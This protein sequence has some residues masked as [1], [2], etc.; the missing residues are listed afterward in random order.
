[1]AHGA[2]Q[3]SAVAACSG[4]SLRALVWVNQNR[5]SRPIALTE[6]RVQNAYATKCS[7]SS[8]VGPTRATNL[9]VRLA[10]HQQKPQPLALEHG[11]PAPTASPA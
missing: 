2:T 6:S 11:W 3:F 4:Y 5:P 7:T 10:M 9:Y 1:M 8:T